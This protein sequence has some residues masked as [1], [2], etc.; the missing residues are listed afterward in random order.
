MNKSELIE[1]LAHETD[2]PKTV[3]GRMLD[4]ILDIVTT[5]LAKGEDVTLI[6]FGTFTVSKRAARTARNPQTGATVKVKATTVP[7]FRAGAALKAAV[8]HKKRA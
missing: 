8:A 6:G 3:A 7:K 2:L 4:T 5:N 1:A